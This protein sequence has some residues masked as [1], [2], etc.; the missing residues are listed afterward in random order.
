MN[1]FLLL[2]IVFGICHGYPSKLETVITRQFDGSCRLAFFTEKAKFDGDDKT[3]SAKDLREAIN[4]PKPDGTIWFSEEKASKCIEKFDTANDV[5]TDKTS[6]T[7]EEFCDFDFWF[8][9]NY[10]ISFSAIYRSQG[11]DTICDGPPAFVGRF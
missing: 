4:P 11:D 6:W 5:D 3:M 1:Y 8:A 7:F 2:G 9:R 10:P